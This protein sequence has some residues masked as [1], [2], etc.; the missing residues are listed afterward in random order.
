MTDRVVGLDLLR[1]LCAFGVATYHF[2]S[3]LGLNIVSLNVGYYA[4][5]VFF[6]ISGA[7]MY[8]SYSK[9]LNELNDFENFLFIRYFRL[10]PLF[11]LVLLTG[12]LIQS[13]DLSGY[14]T[15]FWHKLPLN[16]SE[17]EGLNPRLS[18]G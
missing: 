1:G 4:V 9:R 5:Y 13:Y 12:P 10:L 2:S 17:K 8:L 15:N 3:W 11:L 16:S 18:G 6:V 14:N 7:S